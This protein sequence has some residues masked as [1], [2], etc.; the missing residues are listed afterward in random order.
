MGA[1]Q[2]RVVGLDVYLVAVEIGGDAE[3]QS[4]YV[5]TNVEDDTA[6]PAGRKK[7]FAHFDTQAGTL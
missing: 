6:V 7:L 1:W 3:H 2:T 4:S 5:F